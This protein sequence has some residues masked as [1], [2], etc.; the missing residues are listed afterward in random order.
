MGH[1]KVGKSHPKRWPHARASLLQV[2]VSVEVGKWA[3][4]FISR[5][6]LIQNTNILYYEPDFNGLHILEAI[7]IQELTP[8]INN[9]NTGVQR[10]L[11]LT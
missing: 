4:G 5:E 11:K 9:Q 6:N 1:I 7:L 8:T 2:Q 3:F 10:T